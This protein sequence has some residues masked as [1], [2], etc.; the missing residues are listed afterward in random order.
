MDRRISFLDSSFAIPGLKRETWGTGFW[1][2][3]AKEK[4]TTG[5]SFV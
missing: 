1:W 4:C 2:E 3:D 5:S